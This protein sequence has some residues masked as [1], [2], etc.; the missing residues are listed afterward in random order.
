M[1]VL[2]VYE[3][4]KSLIKQVENFELEAEDDEHEVDNEPFS[5]ESA[6]EVLED[7]RKRILNFEKQV[8][9][10]ILKGCI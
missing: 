7:I 10:K 3:Q 2:P 6:L 8:F 9:G 5:K 4:L 1:E